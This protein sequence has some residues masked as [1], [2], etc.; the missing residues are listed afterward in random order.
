MLMASWLGFVSFVH[1]AGVGYQRY[2]HVAGFGTTDGTLMFS[3]I[4]IPSGPPMSWPQEDGVLTEEVEMAA[5]PMFGILW[6]PI[7]TF[8]NPG[9]PGWYVV[10]QMWVLWALLLGWV[11]WRELRWRE[12]RAKAAQG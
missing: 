1:N 3:Y 8:P 7:G 4:S 12:K 6:P 2:P 11:V 10:I 5:A 9:Y